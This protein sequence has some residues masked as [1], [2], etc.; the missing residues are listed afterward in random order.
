MSNTIIGKLIS[1]SPIQQ[2]SETFSVRTFV[3]EISENAN[4]QVY[5]NYAEFQLV[6]N[7]CQLLD[8]FRPG[9]H[10]TVHFNVRGAMWDSPSGERKCITNLNAWKIELLQ[11]P[12][13]QPQAWNNPPAQ[14]AQQAQPQ[15][16]WGATQ[17]TAQPAAAQPS[18]QPVTQPAWGSQQVPQGQPA[19]AWGQAPRPTGDLP[20]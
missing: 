13:N 10:V 12:N 15:P 6:N 19:Q 18:T 8:S 9:Q 4:G 11:Q 14:P 7:N 16:A 2:K 3:V 5:T 1:A 17:Q 20:F